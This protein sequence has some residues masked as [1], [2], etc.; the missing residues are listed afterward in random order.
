MESMK[1]K[2]FEYH[3]GDALV[4][5]ECYNSSKNKGLTYFHPHEDE[6]T[7]YET[8]KHIIDEF[9]GSGYAI[10]QNGERLISFNL[11][12]VLYRIDPN[13]MFSIDGIRDNLKN[14]GSSSEEAV[15]DISKFSTWMNE[16]IACNT[17]C[18]MHNNFNTSYNVNS[19]RQ[20]GKLMH[21]IDDLY[22]NIDESTGN[23]LYTNNSYLFAFAKKNKTNVV[24]QGDAIL[25][26]DDG[27]YSA[28]AQKK[29][30][31]YINIEATRGDVDNNIK[32]A[33]MV[34]GF[35]DA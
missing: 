21:G 34:N 23:F 2:L 27:S 12:G 28:F 17:I 19:Y 26:K 4:R 32:L 25:D 15:N 16:I 18:A 22:I 31:N 35:F 20:D 5:L 14:Y 11:N 9:G 33:I 3:L 30:I 7:S 24:L 8:M 1:C 6:K 10:K 29:N 13:R